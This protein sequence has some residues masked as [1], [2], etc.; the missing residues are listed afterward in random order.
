MATIVTVRCKAFAGQ[1]IRLQSCMVCDDGSVRVLDAVAGYYTLCHSLGAAA[2][3]RARQLAAKQRRQSEPCLDLD[4]LDAA[5]RADAAGRT[6][7][8]VTRG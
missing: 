7:R 3:R 2:S 6:G 5:D 8:G 1:G 4:A